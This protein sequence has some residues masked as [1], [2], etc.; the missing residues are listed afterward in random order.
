M[1]NDN[2]EMKYD[3]FRNDVYDIFRD[4]VYDIFL[5]QFL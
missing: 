2:S 1:F 4:D 5:G 3:I